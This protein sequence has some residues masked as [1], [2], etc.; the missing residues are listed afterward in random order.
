MLIDQTDA[1][2]VRFKS[3]SSSTFQF[4]FEQLGHE[5]GFFSIPRV[6]CL[7]VGQTVFRGSTLT[8]A[9]S[10]VTGARL[11]SLPCAHRPWLSCTQARIWRLH[12]SISMFQVNAII[13][14]SMFPLSQLE[15]P[16]TTA[17]DCHYYWEP[18]SWHSWQTYKGS[19]F[20]E[21][22]LQDVDTIRSS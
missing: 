18:T 7:T 16:L 8:I 9:L 12:K 4:E 19:V 21:Q 20:P 11:V 17:T 22:V 2:S 1:P 15:K 3:T 13:N 10:P 6:R 5:Y 14:D